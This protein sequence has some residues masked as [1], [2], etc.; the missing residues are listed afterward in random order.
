MREGG[1]GAGEAL[2]RRLV[3]GDHGDGGH[4]PGDLGVDAE[5]AQRLGHGVVGVGMGGVALLPQEL[6]RAEEQPGS[7]LP[8]HDVGPLVDEQRAGRG[9]SRDPPA[10]HLADHRL[11][12]RPDDERLLQL[13]AAGVGDDR[14]LGAEPLDVLGLA[15][16]GSSSGMSSGK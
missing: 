2:T 16:R 13:V 6:G 12:G 9:T 10:V 1:D 7:Q 8:A 4:V 15:L 11:A 5:H 3:A 14:Q